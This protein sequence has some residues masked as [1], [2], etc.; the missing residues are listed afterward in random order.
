MHPYHGDIRAV[1]FKKKEEIKGS[2]TL[3]KSR[4]CGS[5]WFP[6]TK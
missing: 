5:V 2:K 4:I 1:L 3:E 6:I